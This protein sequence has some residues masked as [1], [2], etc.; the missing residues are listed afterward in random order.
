MSSHSVSE[1]P[2]RFTHTVDIRYGECDQQGVVFN[3]EYMAYV[4]DAMDHWMRSVGDL[5]WV[6]SWD[7]MLKK[8]TITWE[9][10]ARWT[11]QL[12]IDC[13]VSRWGSTSF[14]AWFH[15]RVEDRA[16]AEVVITYV[17]VPQGGDVPMI[18]PDAVR[19]ALGDAVPVSW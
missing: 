10:P 1:V 5:G 2:P 4:D 19:A 11:E 18:T 9:S 16:V 17:S 7:V 8:A 3:A 12:S 6:D 13:R 14:D 15:L